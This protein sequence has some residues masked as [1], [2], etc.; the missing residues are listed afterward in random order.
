[1]CAKAALLLYFYSMTNPRPDYKF[2]YEQSQKR[3][4]ETEFKAQ[5]QVQRLAAA[6]LK[7]Q[8]Q[9]RDLQEKLHLALLEA[10]GLRLKL[11]GI[12]SDN[13]V[14]KASEDQLD[15]FSLRSHCPGCCSIRGSTPK[16]SQRSKSAAGNCRREKKA[17]SPQGFQNGVA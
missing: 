7:A 2:L 1:M 17:S 11:F 14:T 9:V 4:A 10:N 5:Q 16:R 15:L 6:E 8:Q 3:L 12:K 13:R